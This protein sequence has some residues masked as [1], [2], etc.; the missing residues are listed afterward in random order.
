[1][2]R[3]RTETAPEITVNDESVVWQNIET[4]YWKTFLK[5]LKALS[6]PF[7]NAFLSLSFYFWLVNTLIFL[8]YLIVK[9]LSILL[10]GYYY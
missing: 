5:D 4:D 6:K 3:L 7:M 8:I 10:T 1:M 2:A 9:L